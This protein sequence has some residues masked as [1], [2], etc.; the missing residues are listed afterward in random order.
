MAA[1]SAVSSAPHVCQWLGST[2]ERRS[3]RRELKTLAKSEAVSEQEQARRMAE[4]ELR[5][6]EKLLHAQ[7]A[8]TSQVPER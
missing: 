8:D 5:E 1:C 4:L 6:Q 3:A 7:V 2:Q